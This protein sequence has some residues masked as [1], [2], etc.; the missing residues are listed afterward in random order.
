MTSSQHNYK[1]QIK[2]CFLSLFDGYSGILMD[3]HIQTLAEAAAR[4]L[5]HHYRQAH[6]A[7]DGDKLPLDHLV[8]WL[9]PDIATF[10]PDQHPKSTDGFIGADGDEH[11]IWLCQDLSETLRRFTLA[12]ELGHALLHCVHTERIQTILGESSPLI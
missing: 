9:R 7:W 10:Y 1:A 2:E 11:L 12:H 5:L 4:L 8:N 3:Q 6:P